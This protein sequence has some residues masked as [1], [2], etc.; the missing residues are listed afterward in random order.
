MCLPT[1]PTYVETKVER[2]SPRGRIAL[3]RAIVDGQ[4]QASRA[5]RDE[6][7]FCLGCLACETACPAGVD[8]TQLFEKARAEAERVQGKFSPL[9]RLFRWLLLDVLFYR[10]SRLRLV[11]RMLGIYQATG[12]QA[13]V[14][15]S[16][17]LCLLPEKMRGLEAK[18]PV[19]C[20]HFSPALIA[21][22]ER[23]ATEPRYRV[24]LLTGCVQDLIYSDINRDTADV[25]LAHGCEVVTPPQQAC[26]GSPPRPQW[27]I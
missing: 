16:G 5:F 21:S 27:G 8:Y 22:P 18:T 23:P 19:V 3:M 14:R 10:Q 1:C 25:L 15:G 9:R 17:L 13:F 4:L 26:C 12:L 24:G 7:Y 20:R 6:M 11:G 2:N